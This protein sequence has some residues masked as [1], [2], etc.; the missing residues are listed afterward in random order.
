MQKRANVSIEFSFQFLIWTNEKGVL[1]YV[2]H[3][4]IFTQNR[5]FCVL[6]VIKLL[7]AF[8]GSFCVRL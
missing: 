1:L 7:V 2:L 8:A 6:D 5:T 4:D 3:R